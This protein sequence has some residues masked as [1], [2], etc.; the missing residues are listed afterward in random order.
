MAVFSHRAVVAAC[1]LYLVGVLTA[2][3]AGS[4]MGNTPVVQEQRI[5]I[6][7][8]DSEFLPSQPSVVRV[9]MSTIIILRNQDIVRHGFTSL[10]LAGMSIS[11][12]GEGMVAYGTGITGFYVNPGKTLV[13]RF[14]PESPGRYGFR[15]DL[16]PQMKGEVFL[17]HLGQA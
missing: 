13:I 2:F 4:V 3:E 12:E 6:V 1:G 10:M 14:T 16:H 7:I 17:L 9:G 8:R 5:E 11:G 15:C